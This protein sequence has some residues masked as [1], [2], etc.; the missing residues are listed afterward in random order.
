MLLA[1]HEWRVWVTDETQTL[2]K[3]LLFSFKL[4]TERVNHW[5]HNF[6]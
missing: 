2:R 5:N 4:S 3:E 1:H 6:L